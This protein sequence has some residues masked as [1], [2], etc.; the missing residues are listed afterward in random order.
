MVNGIG[1]D[2]ERVWQLSVINVKRTKVYKYLDMTLSEKGIDM[3]GAAIYFSAWGVRPCDFIFEEFQP[4][5]L[6]LVLT[7]IAVSL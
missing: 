2:A 3:V 7:Y 5:S 4:P 6:R 1:V